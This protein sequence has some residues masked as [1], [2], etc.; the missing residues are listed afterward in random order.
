MV[1]VVVESPFFVRRPLVGH[2]GGELRA[3]CADDVPSGAHQP[4][5]SDRQRQEAFTDW[6]HWYD[7]HRPHTGI[8]G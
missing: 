1:V 2:N 4:Y 5:A 7:Y 6:L 8:Q 3:L